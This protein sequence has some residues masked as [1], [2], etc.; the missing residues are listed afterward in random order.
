MNSW[1]GSN[2]LPIIFRQCVCLHIKLQMENVCSLC[3]DVSRGN[4]KTSAASRNEKPSVAQAEPDG[5]SSPT[6]AESRGIP[7]SAEK[8]T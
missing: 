4:G 1:S 3:L 6:K 2:T 7:G 8:V 5:V